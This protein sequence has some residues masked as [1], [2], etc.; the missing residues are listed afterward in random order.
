MRDMWHW[1]VVGCSSGCVHELCSRDGVW[2]DGRDQH[3][4]LRKLWCWDVGGNCGSCVHKLHCWDVVGCVECHKLGDLCKLWSRHLVVVNWGLSC[5]NLLELSH[6]DI[7]C[8]GRCV[9][10]H[11]V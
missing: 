1:D 11:D 2:G 4:D 8:G 9:C 6:W 10:E 3:I 7:K 5:W